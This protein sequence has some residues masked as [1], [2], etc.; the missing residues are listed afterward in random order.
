MDE[1]NL[2][3]SVDWFAQCM[4]NVLRNHDGDKG[5]EGWKRIHHDRL[6]AMLS[7]ELKELRWQLKGFTPAKDSQR[8]GADHDWASSVIDECA[9][10]ANFAMMI[11]DNM[12][13]HIDGSGLWERK[14]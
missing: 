12:R 2:R 5:D 9:D 6:F 14:K 13:R 11:A 10:V 7:A 8:R 1:I 4:E 3:E